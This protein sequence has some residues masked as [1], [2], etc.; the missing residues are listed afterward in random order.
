MVWLMV[1]TLFLSF[2]A[3]RVTAEST[4]SSTSMT[5]DISNLAFELQ[6]FTGQVVFNNYTAYVEALGVAGYPHYND[7]LYNGPPQNFMV[8]MYNYTLNDK[9][10]YMEIYGYANAQNATSEYNAQ[11]SITKASYGYIFY[12]CG[13]PGYVVTIVSEGN[14]D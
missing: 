1:A 3:V 11:S 7:Y 4:G 5:V 14:T 2:N 12:R 8:V 9:V 13:Y 6:G 10:V